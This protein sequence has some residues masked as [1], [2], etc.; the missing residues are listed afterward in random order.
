MQEI[1]DLTQAVAHKD[2]GINYS[3]ATVFDHQ[4]L[5]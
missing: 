4:V 2:T 3:D 5:V 1:N